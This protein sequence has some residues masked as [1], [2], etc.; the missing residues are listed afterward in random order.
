MT[1]TVEQTFQ[2][3]VGELLRGWRERRRLSQL[4]LANRV[5][6]STR[7]VSFVE[8]GRS[9]PSREMVLRL[10]EHLDVPLRDRN[11]LLLAGGFAP[12][13]S[14]ASLHSP[15]MLAI[16]QS[17]R[18]L[19]KAHEPYPA[20]VVDRWWNIVEAN[21]G[22]DLFTEGVAP[23]LLAAP[24]NALRLTLH[25]DGLARRITNLPEVRASALTTLQRQ[26]AST[27]DP[28][29]QDLYDEL[30]AY[31]VGP[32]EPNGSG[33]HG[34]AEVVVPMKLRHGDR[35][36]SLLTTIATFGTPLDVTV[37]ELMIE[38]FFPADEQTAAFLQER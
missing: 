30:R 2:R 10:A 24:V 9:K 5:E 21:A 20:L 6:V 27:A 7:H 14:E 25:P 26:V 35:E 4:D 31:P 11:Q 1:A 36:L 13:Y 32:G 3:P 38:Q 16:R 8:T 17:L 19:L 22:I 12:I 15:A 23:E 28:D 33:E 29:L 37:S 34:S 18:R